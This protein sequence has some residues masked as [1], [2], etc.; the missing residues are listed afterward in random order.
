M[1][2][3]DAPASVAEYVSLIKKEMQEGGIQNMINSI[4]IAGDL[5]GPMK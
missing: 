4:K 5:N 1:T 3:I 2:C